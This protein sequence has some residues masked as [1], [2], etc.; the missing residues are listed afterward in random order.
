MRTCGETA[1]S[2][3]RDACAATC[4]H[5]EQGSGPLEELPGN[6]LA[7]FS[8]LPFQILNQ[9][10]PLIPQH[11]G[12]LAFGVFRYAGINSTVQVV[13]SKKGTIC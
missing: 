7:E 4:Q 10:V 2:P 3:R 9:E 5:T 8:S 1:L 11:S 6:H 12:L 13:L